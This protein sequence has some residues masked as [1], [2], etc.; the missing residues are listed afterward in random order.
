MGHSD[1]GQ[2]RADRVRHGG[3]V[4]ERVAGSLGVCVT[5]VRVAV[6]LVYRALGTHGGGGVSDDSGGHAGC[7]VVTRL[8]T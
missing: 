4:T 1:R 6:G 5:G 3:R 8:M 7:C 2:S